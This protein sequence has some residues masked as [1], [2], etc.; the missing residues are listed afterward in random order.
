[1]RTTLRFMAAAVVAGVVAGVTGFTLY[2]YYGH[3]LD[4]QIAAGE[5]LP[6]D[7][8]FTGLNG[9]H[10]ALKQWRGKLVLINF[11]ATWCVP[12]RKEIPL[13]VQ[14]QRQWGSKGLQIIGPAVDDPTAVRQ[15]MPALGIDYPVMTGSPESMIALMSTLGN[16]PGGLPFSVL[17]APDGRVVER[18]LGEF[19]AAGLKRLIEQNLPS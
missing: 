7:I 4:T 3:N 1:M 17:I 19:D 16:A 15:K 8:H 10:Y 13:L 9:Q 11:W 18:H 14:A 12:C 6:G 5:P 2:H